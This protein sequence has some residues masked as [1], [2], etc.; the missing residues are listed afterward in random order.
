MSQVWSKSDK[1]V[2]VIGYNRK[3]LTD[4]RADRRTAPYH[5]TSHFL[6]RAYKNLNNI[7]QLLLPAVTVES[8]FPIGKVPPG[9]PSLLY[10]I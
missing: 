10:P 5:N 2:G 8:L 7:E 6:K 1:N 4:V 9:T 3:K